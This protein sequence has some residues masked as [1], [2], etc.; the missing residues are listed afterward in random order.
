[1][2][3]LD[4]CD[5]RIVEMDWPPQ[6]MDLDIPN[7]L[8]QAYRNQSRYIVNKC[9]AIMALWDGMEVMPGGCG[10]AYVVDLC[11]RSSQGQ[12]QSPTPLEIVSVRREKNIGHP[13]IR[14]LLWSDQIQAALNLIRK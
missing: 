7:L 11:K 2:H 4:S 5:G 6:Q 8:D 1:L 9:D 3:L 10:T 14:Q 12:N 13:L